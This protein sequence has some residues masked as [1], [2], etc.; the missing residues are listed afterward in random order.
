MK[1]ILTLF[2]CIALIL[3]MSSCGTSASGRNGTTYSEAYISELK[4]TYPEFFGL[5]VKKGLTVYVWQMSAGSYF[6]ELREKPLEETLRVYSANAREMRAIL[7]TYKIKTEDVEIVP[8]QNPFSS[9]ISDYFIIG[10]DESEEH[11]QARRQEYIDNVR[12]MLFGE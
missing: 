4:S 9:Y 7:S 10:N 12:D 8:S 2:L 5:S 3:S 6:F 1:K 11:I